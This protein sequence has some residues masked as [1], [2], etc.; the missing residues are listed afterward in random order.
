M[1]FR[2]INQPGRI[3]PGENGGQA[4]RSEELG[5]KCQ[6]PEQA[7][8][9][10]IGRVQWLMQTTMEVEIMESMP[11]GSQS[12]DASEIARFSE[13]RGPGAAV[14][15]GVEERSGDLARR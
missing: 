5:S 6:E 12:R 1:C 3:S 14:G 7:V 13:G 9:L 11:C 8:V 10:G 2:K 15:I 4:G